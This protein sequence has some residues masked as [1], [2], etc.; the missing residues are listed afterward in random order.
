MQPATA[1]HIVTAGDFFARA[2]ERL[3]LDVPQGLT[4]PTITPRRGDHDA[5]PVMQK[6]AEVRPIRP[7]AVL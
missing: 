3:T 6:I 7:A 2:H 5:D 1:R 4:D